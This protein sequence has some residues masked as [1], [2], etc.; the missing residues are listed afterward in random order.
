MRSLVRCTPCK[1]ALGQV[2]IFVR[3]FG[4]ADLWSDV[5]PGRDISCPSVVLLLAGWPLVRCIPSRDIPCPYMVLLW[6][7][8]ALFR[9]SPNRDISCP[10]AVLL[11][12]GWPLVRCTPAPVE[13]SCVQEWYYIEMNYVKGFMINVLLV[14]WVIN[15]LCSII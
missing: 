6:A 11:W 2:D 13:T 15:N 12:A 1:C 3:S 5:T 9:C 4:H 14:Q 10:C 7:D 8:W